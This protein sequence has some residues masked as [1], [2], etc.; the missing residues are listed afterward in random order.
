[1]TDEEKQKPRY[2][3]GALKVGDH[4]RLLRTATLKGVHPSMLVERY[5]LEGMDR[6]IKEVGDKA[7][8]A[9]KM[10]ILDLAHQEHKV[11]MNQLRQFAYDATVFGNQEYFDCL[12]AGCELVG[13]DPDEIIQQ[14]SNWKERPPSTRDSGAGVT[15]AMTW[16]SSVVSPGESVTS[17]DIFSMGKQLGFTKD[18]L[19]SAKKHL[20][21]EARKLSREWHWQWPE[22]AQN[23]Q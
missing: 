18:V 19:R 2:A 14:V 15:S 10:F 6:D 21:L 23:I 16:L 1:M 8:D 5:I 3:A 9:D 7:T 20:G 11:M 13:V 12:E 17:N 4:I 22:S